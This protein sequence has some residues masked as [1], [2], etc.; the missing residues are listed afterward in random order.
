MA[1]RASDAHTAYPPHADAIANTRL[2]LAEPLACLLDPDMTSSRALPLLATGLVIL[3][4][5]SACGLGSA[6]PQA[7]GAPLVTAVEPAVHPPAT[8]EVLALTPIPTLAPSPASPRPAIPESR[9]LTLEF[10]PL[11]RVGDSTRIRMQLEVDEMGNLTPTAVVEGNVV[12]GETVTIPN[13]YDTHRVFV[14]ARLDLA[15]MEVS[16][17]GLVREPLQP[18]LPV[19]FYW[20]IHPA[21]P[22]VYQGAAWLYLHFIP[23]AGGEESRMPISVQFMDIEARSLW[24]LSGSAARSIG[25]IGST[26]SAILGFPFMD[27]LLKWLWGKRKRIIERAG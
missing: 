26:V 9:R 10:P 20:S 1:R 3:A 16:P 4:A 24:G 12:V 15:G 18:G 19:V 13:L 7:P 21:S 11:M 22:G 25:M 17:A 6:R 2:V 23:L 27:D 14:E 5:V 8:L